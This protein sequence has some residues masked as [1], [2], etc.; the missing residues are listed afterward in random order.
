MQPIQTGC[1]RLQFGQC[2]LIGWGACS[3]GRSALNIGKKM[4]DKLELAPDHSRALRI[5]PAHVARGSG[6]GALA[7]SQTVIK[8]LFRVAGHRIGAGNP[9]WLEQAPVQTANAWAVQQWLDAGADVIGI[10]HTDE[11]ALSLSGTNVHYGT[12]LNTKA[13]DRIPGGSSSGSAAAVAAGLVPYAMATDTGGSTRVPASYCGIFGIR[14][15]HGRVPVDGLVPLAPRFDTV[16]VLAS[17]GAWLARATG[18]LLPDYAAKPAARCLVVATDVLALADRDAADAVDDAVKAVAK[19]LD[20]E[21]VRTSFADGR[22]QEWKDAFLARQPVEVWKTHGEW[23][24]GNKPKFGPGIGLRFEMAS[25]ADPARANLADMAAEQI[26]AALEKH[27]PPGG[28]LAFATASG[29]APKL[30]LPAAEKQSLR[31]RTIA[32]TCIAGLAG[33]PAVSVPAASVA[34]LPLGLCLLARRGEDEML[35]A[36]AAALEGIELMR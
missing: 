5:G 10:A 4:T 13:P 36:T 1:V 20:I 15:T 22:L 2:H 9:V 27:V 33:V 28:V 25:K 26:L 19:H 34:G 21:T 11:L 24:E 14:T 12:P 30:E 18:P 29:A 32:M 17:S 23:I 35:L 6:S 8:D 7:G 16:G 3:P 31:D